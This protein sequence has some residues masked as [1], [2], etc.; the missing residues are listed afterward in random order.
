[1]KARGLRIFRTNLEVRPISCLVDGNKQLVSK[2][3]YWMDW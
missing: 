1:M 2:N 3:Y